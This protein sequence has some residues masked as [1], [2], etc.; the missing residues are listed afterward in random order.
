MLAPPLLSLADGI[1][2]ISN[3]LARLV[4]AG[5]L[6]KHS[7][8]PTRPWYTIPNGAVP[9][10]ESDVWRRI[11]DNGNPQSLLATAEMLRVISGNEQIRSRLKL[12]KEL[13]PTYSAAATGIRI[14]RY[15]GDRLGWS[16]VQVM[17]VLKDWFY[18]LATNASEHWKSALTF[19]KRRADSLD[20]Y[21]ETVMGMGYVHTSNVA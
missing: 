13:K 4:D 9:K 1:E 15:I 12:P 21:Q 20:F 6:R 14:H 3:E 17:D 11:S 18:Q 5:Y 10:A 16:L 8:Q 2:S 19:A 7:K